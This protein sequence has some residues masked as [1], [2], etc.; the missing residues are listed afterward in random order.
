MTDRDCQGVGGIMRNGERRQ[1]QQHL[2]HLLHLVLIG[3]SIAHHRALD[4][5]RRVLDKAYAGLDRGRA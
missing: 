4:L 1:L 5:S 3:P 2:D